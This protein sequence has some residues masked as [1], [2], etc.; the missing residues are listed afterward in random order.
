MIDSDVIESI[1]TRY[2]LIY[3]SWNDGHDLRKIMTRQKIY[4]HHSDLLVYGVD[5]AI[6]Q[7]RHEADTSNVVPIR[8]VLVGQPVTVPDWALNTPLYFQPSYAAAA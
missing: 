6:K 3:K 4:R 8:V 1:P 2:K 7:D 5:I